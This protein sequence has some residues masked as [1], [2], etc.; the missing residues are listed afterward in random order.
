MKKERICFN[1]KFLDVLENGYYYCDMCHCNVYVRDC[2]DLFESYP[3]IV[4]L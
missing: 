4:L 1:C 3:E 2:C